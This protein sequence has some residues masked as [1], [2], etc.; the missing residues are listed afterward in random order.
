MSFNFM[1]SWLQ[2]LSAVI[3][4]PKKIK[5]A[6]VSTF[7]PSICHEVMGPDAMILVFWMLSFKPTFSLS[8][9]TFKGLFSSSISTVRVVSSAYM[10]LLIFLL[11]ILIPACASS[12]LAFH[13]MYSAYKLNKEGDNIQPSL[14]VFNWLD[15]AYPYYGGQSALLRAY[16][17]KC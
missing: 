15:E 4:E 11:A 9:F 1:I 5:F 8:S 10:R 3:L 6:T 17:C 7:S 14:K 13:M 2:S 12:S 16:W